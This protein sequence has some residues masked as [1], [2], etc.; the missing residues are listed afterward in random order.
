MPEDGEDEKQFYLERGRYLRLPEVRDLGAGREYTYL[1]TV[2]GRPVFLLREDLKEEEK[3]EIPAA[4][5][6]TVTHPMG[7]FVYLRSGPHTDYKALAE[8]RHGTQVEVLQAGEYWSKIRVNGL[9]GY[10]VSNYLK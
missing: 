4:S 7:S 2:D 6:R 3:Q 10:M 5:L 1:F 9:E 8:I